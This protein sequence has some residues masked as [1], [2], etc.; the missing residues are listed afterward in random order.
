MFLE[1][2][3]KFCSARVI[4]IVL[5]LRYA[6]IE[7]GLNAAGVSVSSNTA[8]FVDYSRIDHIIYID[9]YRSRLIKYCI[10]SNQSFPVFEGISYTLI[11]QDTEIFLTH[12][13]RKALAIV[14][15]WVLAKAQE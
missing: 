4:N 5:W 13:E 2:Y 12:I 3:L 8:D 1:L 7:N 10:T 15:S 14:V 11:Q 6:V 9:R